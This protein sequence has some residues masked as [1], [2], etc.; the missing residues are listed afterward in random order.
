MRV[1][2]DELQLQDLK[3]MEAAA[4]VSREGAESDSQLT[5][6]RGAAKGGACEA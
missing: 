4:L 1:A 6:G 5:S 2:M 3:N